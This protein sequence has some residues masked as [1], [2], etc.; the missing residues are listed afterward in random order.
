MTRKQMLTSAL[1][2]AVS[3]AAAA[4][5]G[6]EASPGPSSAAPLAAGEAQATADGAITAAD[7]AAAE[8]IAGITFTDEQR[9]AIL[10][11]V[12]G[13]PKA[14]EAIRSKPIPYTAEPPTHFVPLG[15]GS[16]PGAKVRAVVIS[17]N[18][19][20]RKGLSEEQ[21]AFLSVRQLSA[22]VK[23][24]QLSPVEL[25]RLY[26]DRLKQYGDKL[27]CVITLMEEQAL[28]Q[29]KRCESEIAAGHYRGPLHGIPYGIKDLFATKGVPTTWGAEPYVHQVFDYNARV[30][31]R[32]EEAGAILLAKLSMG[33]LAMDDHWQ[34]GKTKNP[35]NP[36]EG[37]SGSSAGSASATAAGLVGFSIGTETL[38]SIMSPSHRCRVTGLRPTYGRVSRYGAMGL[39]YTMD[40]V[41][42][43]CREVED[44]AL[45]FAA[46]CGPDPND[47]TTVARS[48]TWRPRLDFKALKVGCLINPSASLKD[49][50]RIDKEP[51]VQELR[52]RGALVRPV[53]FTPAPQALFTILE[54]ESASAFDA[55]TRSADLDTI[56]SSAWPNI[57]RTNRF[58]PAV[59]YLQCQR[60]RSLAMRQFEQEFG[61]L[62][63]FLANGVGGYSLTLTN[64]TGHPQVLIPYGTN[65]AGQNASMTL[66][67][68][69]YQE[70]RLLSV[71]KTLQDSCKFTYQ[72]A[73]P[74]LSKL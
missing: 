47:E 3:T 72:Y 52:S 39:S 30:V 56:K 40:K 64:S 32:L 35:W 44:C 21:L 60:L 9:A 31:D 4:C 57:F 28:R 41:G 42:P 25:T 18:P 49:T 55:L 24:R 1:A 20:A 46:I 50:S 14:F 17:S 36:K 59:E 19:V 48:F 37:S 58:V 5:E 70:D 53:K 26:L 8:R 65:P 11:N 71:A 2:V 27:L 15:G 12:R 45:V 61:D 13:L 10:S 74:D 6:D 16:K 54:V 22:L 43:I 23:S 66:I 51:F 7:L 38:G 34:N 67:G 73:R 68:R 29:A 63:M 33:A 69:L 62:D